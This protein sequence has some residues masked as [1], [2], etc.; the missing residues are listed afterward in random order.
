MSEEKRKNKQWVKGQCNVLMRSSARI[1]IQDAYM[2]EISINYGL[3]IYTN[4][5]NKIYNFWYK[6][7]K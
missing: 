5:D 1:L 2:Y 3:K 7:D 6:C 4:L